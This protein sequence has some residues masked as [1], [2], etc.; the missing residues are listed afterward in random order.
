[1]RKSK[2]IMNP[3]TALR[4]R[5]MK[6]LA[7]SLLLFV[8]SCRGT[9]LQP[10]RL[11]IDGTLRVGSLNPRYFTNRSGRSILLTGSTTWANLVDIGLH[12]PPRRFDY[13]EYLAFL[14]KNNHNFFR[15]YAWEQSHW[16]PDSPVKKAEMAWFAPLPYRRV[17]PGLALDGKPKFDLTKF[18]DDY[19]ARLRERVAMAGRQG[20]YVSV[21][22][23]NGFSIETKGGKSNPW[24]GHPYN[25]NNNVNGING[26]LDG[27]GE[28]REVHTLV[29][30]EVLH[31]QEE[32]VKRVVDSVNDLDNVLFEIS[33][34]SRPD[35]REWQ[36]H[37]I[38]FVKEYESH[39]PKQ[40]P[41]GMTVAWP[42]GSNSDLLN[43]PADWIS[44]NGSLS[45]N[46]STDGRKVILDDTDHLC[47]VCGS[48]AWV[49]ESFLSGRNP[50]FMDPYDTETEF[51][52]SRELDTRMSS[53]GAER[54]NMGY[55]LTYANKIDLTSMIP[56][57]ELTSSRFCLANLAPN[58][59]AYLVYFPNGNGTV[60]VI[61][62]SPL[63]IE[64]F[65][66]STG[67]VYRDEH[68]TDPHQK[69]FSAPFRG[70]AVLYLHKKINDGGT[71]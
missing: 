30:P 43:S 28:G 18:N 50:I 16:F 69:Q 9:V 58:E 57:E 4:V 63:Q 10:V 15:L 14:K 55:V 44:P 8:T 24:K 7:V 19:F 23:F 49:W 27:D 54:R 51:G 60:N 65:R 70:D 41:V 32:Y 33:N 37:M 34:E 56:H 68:M 3:I 6:S 59:T 35:S 61:S 5:A 26:D 2:K 64:W 12:D 62:T 42:D 29:N 53:W 67:E 45:P 66:P 48:V 25:K 47:G 21:M 17:G 40:H 22:L 39:K 11:P 46:G 71:Y 13:D 52:T 38:R 36:Y 31:L 1:M 20:I